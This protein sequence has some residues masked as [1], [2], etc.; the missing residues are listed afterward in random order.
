MSN[1][2]QFKKAVTKAI[3][4]IYPEAYVEIR[5]CTNK[6]ISFAYGKQGFYDAGGSLVYFDTVSDLKD[7]I[8]KI[9]NLKSTHGFMN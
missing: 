2:T 6:R 4:T 3:K 8:D 7:Y 1:Y 5:R 9:F